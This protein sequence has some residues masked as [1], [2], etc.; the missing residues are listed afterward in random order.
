VPGDDAARGAVGA[1]VGGIRPGV[2]AKCFE[3]RHGVRATAG[4][5]TV[6]LVVCFA[7]AWVYV[8]LGPE[9]D[10][11]MVMLTVPGDPAALE[12][13]LTDAGVRRPVVLDELDW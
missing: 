13:V 1:L 12:K 9:D 5:A 2:G 4:D 11:E 8:Y 7:C 6:D 3:P 10:A